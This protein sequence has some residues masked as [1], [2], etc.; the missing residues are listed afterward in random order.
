[1][2]KWKNAPSSCEALTAPGFEVMKLN[3]TRRRKQ[4]RPCQSP[5]C[6][7]LS[8]GPD[9][10]KS[11]ATDSSNCGP[12][13]LNEQLSIDHSISNHNRR[14]QGTA[15][16]IF[17]RG[18]KSKQPIPRGAALINIYRLSFTAHRLIRHEFTESVARGKSKSRKEGRGIAN[19]F[20]TGL[21]HSEFEF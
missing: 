3:S 6:S 5:R 18:N 21:L 17:G 16:R 8:T 1:M 14:F 11:H 9:L 20:E 7:V 4:R 2:E 15:I 13:S 12:T 19:C 10:R